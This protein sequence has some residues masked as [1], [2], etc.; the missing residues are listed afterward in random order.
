MSPD[1][2]PILVVQLVWV[3]RGQEAAFDAYEAVA[4][5]LLPEYGGT[6]LARMKPT[7]EQCREAGV[8]GPSEVHVMRFAS[9]EAMARFSADPRRVA[10][11]PN[12]EA[13]VRSSL[14]L[15]QSEWVAVGGGD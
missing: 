11:L 6:L 3:H 2:D 13:A 14:L 9:R 10:L 12:K 15:V 4:I 5:P 7:A 8:D 1:R